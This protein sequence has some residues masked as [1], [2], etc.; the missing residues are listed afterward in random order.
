LVS[1]K[2]KHEN[3]LLMSQ[4]LMGQKIVQLQSQIALLENII[5]S[6]LEPT[7]KISM[8]HKIQIFVTPPN[9]KHIMLEVEPTDRIETIKP[10]IEDQNG[11]PP[12]KQLFVFNGKDLKDGNSFQDYNIQRDSTL[13]LFLKNPDIIEIF[14]KTLIG[15]QITLQVEPNAR[16]EDVKARI[17]EA[18]GIPSNQQLLLFAGKHLVD[19][20][21]LQDYSIQNNSTLN[22]VIPLYDQ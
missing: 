17:Q 6:N 4:H 12:Q 5:P 20:N 22:L 19:S 2:A 9:G 16:I 8:Y 11:S 13:H 10:K 15:K 1:G 14:V 18:E 3:D 21:T 7:P